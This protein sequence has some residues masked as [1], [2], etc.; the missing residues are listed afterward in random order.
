MRSIQMISE[1]ARYWEIESRVLR[2]PEFL[3]DAYMLDL[4]TNWDG[5]SRQIQMSEFF[6]FQRAITIGSRVADNINSYVIAGMYLMLFVCNPPTPK[7]SSIFSF[8]SHLELIINQQSPSNLG[9]AE[10]EEKETCEQ[11]VEPRTRIRERN[12]LCVDVE[13]FVYRDNTPIILF[14]CRTSDFKNQL[15]TL[16]KNGRIQ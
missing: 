4:K 9:V 16:T 11:S 1:A 7:T 10:E 5:L 2:Y 15:W 14:H 12:G 8:V 3:P 6:A 13:G